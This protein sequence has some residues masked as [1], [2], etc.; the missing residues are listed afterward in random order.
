LTDSIP[1]NIYAVANDTSQV[2]YAQYRQTMTGEVPFI[3]LP[4]PAEF[5]L[6]NVA[7]AMLTGERHIV[8]RLA[9]A[10]FKKKLAD[11]L[12]LESNN[13]AQQ[14]FDWLIDCTFCA[15]DSAGV[16]R[17][18]PCVVLKLAGDADKAVTIMDGAFPSLYP[19]DR[20]E[21]LCSLS[22]ALW[23]PLSKGIKNYF[24]AK[25][26]LDKISENDLALQAANMMES[27]AHYY[28]AVMKFQIIDIM[29]SV[30]AMPLSGADTRLCDVA[31]VGHQMIRVRA[32]KIDAVIAAERAVRN[33]IGD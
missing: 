27:M 14:G 16:D 26:M 24:E 15:G 2:D 4:R 9:K 30:R 18:E 11:C 1:V 5:G 29:K 28:P 33:I 6:Q 31:L 13:R 23:T 7:G 12:H 10:F 17:Y 8:T 25:I 3:D 19:W 32:G 20:S 22:S 21:G